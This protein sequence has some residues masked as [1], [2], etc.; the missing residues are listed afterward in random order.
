MAPKRPAIEDMRTPQAKPDSA[1]A[2]ER[3]A[4]SADFLPSVA[5]DNLV[6]Q[7]NNCDEEPTPDQVKDQQWLAGTCHSPGS[8]RADREGAARTPRFRG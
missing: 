6:D 4:G 7:L 8:L 5:Q 3:Q 1:Q 2:A